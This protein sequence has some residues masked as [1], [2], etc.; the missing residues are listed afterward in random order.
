MASYVELALAPHAAVVRPLLAS[1]DLFSLWAVLLVAIG[2]AHV[3]Q[4][5]RPRSAI[6]TLVLWGAYLALFRFAIP[7]MG[8]SA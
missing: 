1:V 7:R 3:A 4:V 6:T 8:Q 5:S 2:M